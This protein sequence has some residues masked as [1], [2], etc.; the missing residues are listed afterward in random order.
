MSSVSIAV[1]LQPVKYGKPG[2]M[3]NGREN[4]GKLVKVE[5]VR[6]DLGLNETVDGSV[7]DF[8]LEIVWRKRHT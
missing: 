2:S 8:M 1:N 5:V 3:L 4:G 7:T 6:R